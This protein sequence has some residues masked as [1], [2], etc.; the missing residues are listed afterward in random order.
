QPRRRRLLIVEDNPAE[1]LSI[2]ELLGHD[3]I[4]LIT[5][6]TGTEALKALEADPP[7]CIVLDLRL[8]DMSGF[9]LLEALRD[10]PEVADIPVVVFTGRELSAEEDAQL[11]TLARSVVVKGVES[12]ER[13]LDE[14]A[15]FLHRVITN[16]PEDKQRMI[17]RL[18]SSDEDLVG[19]AVLLVDDDARNIF[20]L[21]S[22]LER[23]GMKVLT[24][25]T[26]KEAI[27]LVEAT[28]DLAI[29]LM[30]IMMPEMDGYQ[31]MQVIREDP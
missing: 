11:H 30:D 20:A 31:T 23:R 17:E 19:K 3:D 4:D 21:S 15:L 25:T 16:L 18:H 27:D 24:A 26:G 22:V 12:P 2:G 7:D 6:G 14:T 8:P 5:V 9:D 13:L 1:Q 29:V 10:R 28:P